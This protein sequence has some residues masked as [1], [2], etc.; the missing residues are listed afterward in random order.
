MKREIYKAYLISVIALLAVG[1]ILRNKQLLVPTITFATLVMVADNI[2]Q[3]VIGPKDQ[4]SLCWIKGIALLLVGVCSE[5]LCTSV[6]HATT[7]TSIIVA[8][9]AIFALVALNCLR[10]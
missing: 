6:G 1:L 10:P 2:S 9:E 3:A 8:V 4:A 5:A 7:P